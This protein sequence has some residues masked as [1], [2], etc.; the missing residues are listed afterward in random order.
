[1]MISLKDKHKII[2]WVTA[3]RFRTYIGDCYLVEGAEFREFL[4]NIAVD[5]DMEKETD[6]EIAKR[7][8][9][10]FVKENPTLTALGLVDT[11]LYWLENSLHCH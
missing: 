9:E 6:A 5:F 4:T 1:M 8:W 3:K 10:E 7:I 2:M 11:F